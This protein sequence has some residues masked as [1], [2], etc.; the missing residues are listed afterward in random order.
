MFKDAVEEFYK[1]L[2]EKVGH[3]QTSEGKD[4]NVSNW[5]IPFKSDRNSTLHNLN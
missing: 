5:V 1:S 4:V 2:L 3:V